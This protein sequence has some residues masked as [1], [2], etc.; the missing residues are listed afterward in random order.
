MIASFFVEEYNDLQQW[1]SIKKSSRIA[2]QS[3]VLYEGGL[4]EMQTR[5]E[6]CDNLP[7]EAKHPIILDHSSK[8]K[9]VELD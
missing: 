4:I 7:V 6:Y 2:S 1:K 5:M 8:P 3:L 9:Q